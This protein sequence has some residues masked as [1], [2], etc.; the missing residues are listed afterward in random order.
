MGTSTSNSHW[1]LGWCAAV[2]CFIGPPCGAVAD[3]SAPSDSLGEIVVV[4]QRREQNLMD[5]P[6]SVSALSGKDLVSL[7]FN[8][9][10]QV[11]SQVPGLTFS[12]TGPTTI[13]SI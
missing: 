2:A 11:A 12:N 6:L 1:A 7:G 5:V 8:N 13:F 10:T 9:M 4:A 3:N